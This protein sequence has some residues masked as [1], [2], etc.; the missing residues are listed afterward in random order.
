MEA[1]LLSTASPPQKN[2]IVKNGMPEL[3]T[4]KEGKKE[5][6]KNQINIRLFSDHQVVQKKSVPQGQTVNQI[7]YRKVHK[8]L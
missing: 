2:T 8:W 4:S 3:A 7:F 5:Q 6:I 1:G